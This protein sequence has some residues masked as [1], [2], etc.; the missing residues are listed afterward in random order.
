MNSG[1][2]T[3]ERATALTLSVGEQAL[4]ADRDGRADDLSGRLPEAGAAGTRA[5]TGTARQ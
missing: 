4:G 3:S 2:W 1:D 5:A